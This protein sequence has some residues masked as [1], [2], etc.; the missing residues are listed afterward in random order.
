MAAGSAAATSRLRDA[1]ETRPVRLSGTPTF[2]LY[3]GKLVARPRAQIVDGG[4][5][6]S[7]RGVFRPW[8]DRTPACSV[9]AI[10]TEGQTLRAPP[11]FL[12]F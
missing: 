10:E 9:F 7:P 1:G 12:E 6:R 5:C 4:I 3:R 11:G 8:F 2:L